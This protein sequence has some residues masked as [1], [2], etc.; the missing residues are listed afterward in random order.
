[1]TDIVIKSEEKPDE[2]KVEVKDIKDTLKAADEYKRLKEEND[3]LEA[4]YIRQQELK[5]K[6]TI[7][8]RSAAGQYIPEK[9]PEEKAKEEA[10]ARLKP[11]G[12]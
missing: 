1:M 10:A 6:I 12:Y 9:T 7:G 11:F 4:E 3:K 2:K 5:A 8:G